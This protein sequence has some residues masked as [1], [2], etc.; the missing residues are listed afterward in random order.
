MGKPGSNGA[1]LRKARKR[2]REEEGLLDHCFAVRR[3]IIRKISFGNRRYIDV[4]SRCCRRPAG[5]DAWPWRAATTT[6]PGLSIANIICIA[7]LSLEYIDAIRVAEID[8][9][10]SLLPGGARILE[11]GAGTGKQA[12]E[13]QR[14]GFQ[15]TAI[16][17]ADSNCAAHR[18]FPIT[19]YDGRTIPLPH[20]SIDVVFSSNVLEHVPDLARMHQEIRRVLAPALTRI[21][22]RRRLAVARAGYPGRRGRRLCG[23]KRSESAYRPEV[24]F[25]A[26]A[27]YQAGWRFSA[28]GIKR[29]EVGAI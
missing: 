11:I 4:V 6:L 25:D 24:A 15:V 28:W 26:V 16:E 5:A 9:I 13:L 23:V 20:A 7:V 1:Q 19:D 10:A 2:D 8:K 29:P 14:R 3:A 12:V 17:L 22:S 18:V 27:V 21:R